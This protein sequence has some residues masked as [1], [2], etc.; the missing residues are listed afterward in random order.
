MRAAVHAL[1]LSLHGC[2][3]LYVVL[4]IGGQARDVMIVLKGAVAVSGYALGEESTFRWYRPGDVICLEALQAN[5]P[6][7]WYISCVSM[8]TAT[9][10]CTGIR[11]LVNIRCESEV[12]ISVISGSDAT[13]AVLAS[14]E[15]STAVSA[16]D[17]MH[18]TRTRLAD[19]GVSGGP[20]PTPSLGTEARSVRL[21]YSHLSVGCLTRLI[22]FAHLELLDAL[23]RPL[24]LM[25]DLLSENDR[26]A[27]LCGC[28]M[29]LLGPGDRGTIQ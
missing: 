25:R 11:S 1:L 20:N 10:A 8:R 29:L 23:S 14:M 17:D 2:I 27:M 6:K 22:R 4:S 26:R 7:R 18:R 9:L 21:V 16:A 3:V 15:T 5:V 13:A 24:P 19:G 28:A 12:I